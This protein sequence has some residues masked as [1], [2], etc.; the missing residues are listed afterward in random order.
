[1]EQRAR[2]N[3]PHIVLVK[4][5]LPEV[6]P[7]RPRR[8]WHL[9][10]EGRSRCG[11]LA[12]RLRRYEPRL[13][14]SSPESKAL[15]TATLL[16]SALGTIEPALID[17]LRE[18][19]DEGLPF[20]DEP[21]FKRAARAFFLRPADPVFGRET[22]DEAF[23]RF[24]AA[25]DA[26][27]APNRTTLVVAHGR[28]ISLFVAHRARIEAYPLWLRLGLPSFVVMDPSGRSVIEVVEGV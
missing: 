3:R 28:V 1:M 21:S 13:I 15:E 10:D 18:Q 22:A 27:G 26:L 12:D 23:E 16:G 25:V 2:P 17:D 8:E 19:D 20:L 14:A 7:A 6:A 11:R 24:A 4:H 5:S 9:S